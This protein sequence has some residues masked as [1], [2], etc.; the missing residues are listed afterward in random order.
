MS[1][2]DRRSGMTASPDGTARYWHEDPKTGERVLHDDP[3]TGSPFFVSGVDGD[4]GSA[5][6]CNEA[7]W[8]AFV[9]ERRAR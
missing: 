8:V 3:Y 6:D 1:A 2:E 7:K 5:H 4:T 9:A